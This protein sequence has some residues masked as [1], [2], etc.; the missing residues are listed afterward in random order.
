MDTPHFIIHQC[1][2]EL[3]HCLAIVNHAAMNRDVQ[4]LFESLLSFA[5]TPR[6]AIAGL[7]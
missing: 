5:Y 4:Y 1:T 6:S 2:L 7:W 3:L